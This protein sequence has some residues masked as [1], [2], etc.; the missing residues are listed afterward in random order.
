MRN[1]QKNRKVDM[2]D[3][4]NFTFLPDFCGFTQK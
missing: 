2:Y 1:L 4:L 3:I